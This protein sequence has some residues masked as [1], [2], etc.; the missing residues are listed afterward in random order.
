MANLR[1]ERDFLGEAKVAADALHGV[2]TLRAMEN[3]PLARRP[4]HAELA[5]AYGL[6]KLACAKTNRSPCL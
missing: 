2:H 4:M 1:T 5:K 6:V 3:F